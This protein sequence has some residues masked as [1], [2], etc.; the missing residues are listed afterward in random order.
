[1]KNSGS[2]IRLQT[3]Q[4]SRKEENI[5]P[6]IDIAF[7][8]LIFFMIAGTIRP[9]SD[10]EINLAG[11]EAPTQTAVSKRMIVVRPDG[12]R[13][14]DGRHMS[15]ADFQARLAQWS[16][17]PELPVTIVADRAAKAGQLIEIVT[18]AGAAG[19][20][21]VKLLTRRTGN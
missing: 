19:I 9:F 2:T 4:R 5:V 20:K 15:D 11:T 13:F 18:H 3:P 6:L 7:L 21:D 10:R 14:V 16:E 1:M 12:R 8:I 17:Q